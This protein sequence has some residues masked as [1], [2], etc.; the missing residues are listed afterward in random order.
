[1]SPLST[2][3]Q[4]KELFLLRHAIITRAG[5]RRRRRPLVLALLAKPDVRTTLLGATST[6]DDRP[7]AAHYA[8]S[9]I[10]VLSKVGVLDDVRR[11]G[12]IP[13]DMM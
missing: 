8:P 10:Q 9:A 1:V 4:R 11:D 2:I 6:I 13:E 5:N 12:L 7:R 3:A